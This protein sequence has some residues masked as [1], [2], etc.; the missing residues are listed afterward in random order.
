MHTITIRIFADDPEPDRV[1][2]LSALSSAESLLSPSDD[3]LSSEANA[4]AAK[5]LGELFV[6]TSG[7]VCIVPAA[8]GVVSSAD[9]FT[10]PV[11]RESHSHQGTAS[12]TLSWVDETLVSFFR[13]PHVLQNIPS[14]NALSLLSLM[15]P[16]SSWWTFRTRFSRRVVIIDFPFPFERPGILVKFSVFTVGMYVNLVF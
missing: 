10:L 12:P 11:R 5:V 16:V 13:I 7:I 15:A 2:M 14:I 9:G 4:T 3:A 6:F 8:D 1:G